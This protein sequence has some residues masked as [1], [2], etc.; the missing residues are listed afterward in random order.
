MSELEKGV[1]E[2]EF[3]LV[4]TLASS[5]GAAVVIYDGNDKLIYSSPNFTRFFPIPLDVLKPGARLRDLLGSVFDLVVQ[6]AIRAAPTPPV[7][8]TRDGWIADR[9]ALHWRERYESVE[10][11]PD[12][13]WIRLSKRRLSNGLLVTSVCDVSEQKRRDSDLSDMRDQA[14]LSQHILDNL[15]NPVIVKDSQLRYVIVNDAFC[16]LLGMPAR[17]I[18]GRRASDFVAA[19]AAVAFEENER[20]V[21][22]TGVPIEYVEDIPGADGMVL[23]SITRKRRSGTPGN[24]YLT[25]S[26]DHIATFSGQN[27]APVAATDGGRNG[28][29]PIARILVVDE[30]RTRAAARV[31]E[32]MSAGNEAMAVSDPREVFVFLDTAKAMGLTVDRT[33][34]SQT[35]T[36]MIARYPR[37][38]TYPQLARALE[39]AI[40]PA[41]PPAPASVAETRSPP[42]MQAFA[43]RIETR[44]SPTP[45][46]Q[47]ETPTTAPA[48]R[49]V[50][51]LVA[52]DNE[53]NQIVFEQILEGLSY[54]FSIVD[55][56]AKAVEAW[57]ENR[58][59][60]IL[61]DVSMP[62]MS[63][64]DACAAIRKAEA[65]ESHV[66]IIAVTAHAMTGDEERC[67]A[68]G[69]DDYLTKPVSP[70]RLET[71][72]RAW[73]PA[74]KLGIPAA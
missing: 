34:L 71:V 70:E 48:R 46:P 28:K 37:A 59:D 42:A 64:L 16:R 36:G 27:D 2:A 33:E 41:T 13:R 4:E 20:A 10:Q 25:I 1:G 17:S 35:M 56:G 19:D 11:L 44:Q 24:Y 43:P 50:R 52:E 31:A 12:G 9:V 30:N 7:E 40:T 73:I 5:F 39:L 62:V 58:P 8:I 14:E 69:M 3:S 68:A 22:K 55:N 74:E 38:V 18:L 67:L 6:P 53:V 54:E 26:I 23:R 32:L 49:R 47:V 15:A 63:G 45:V 72:I 61:M 29:S 51:V 65:G 57:R 66:P 21:L 60:I